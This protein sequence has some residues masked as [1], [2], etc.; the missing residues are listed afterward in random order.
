[1]AGPRPREATGPRPREATGPQ[2]REATGQPREATG[3][4]SRDVTAPPT[5]HQ[6]VNSPLAASPS[7]D[8]R[9][10]APA[11][12]RVDPPPGAEREPGRPDIAEPDGQTGSWDSADTTP[13]PV[14]LADAPP[15]A[16]ST[17]A[18]RRPPDEHRPPGE[19]RPASLE[20]PAVPAQAKLEQI[21]DLYLTA[22]AIGEDALVKHFEEV[23]RRQRE[24][25]REYFEQSGV[26]P[27]GA[28]RLLGD[29]PAPDEAPLPG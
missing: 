25:I 28:A 14:I 26:G 19:H 22:E 20:R 4:W 8:N 15:P 21:K 18:H 16:P 24:L 10:G 23:S 29:N 17:G 2:P 13:L 27:K 6:S 9:T 7:G 5:G 12:R 11:R 3:W 1:M